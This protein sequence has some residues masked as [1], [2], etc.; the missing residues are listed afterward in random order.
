MTM[1]TRN[2]ALRPTDRLDVSPDDATRL[3]LAEGERVRV[4]SQYGHA[5][6][7]LH[8][9]DSVKPGELFATFSDPHVFLNEL[10]GPHRDALT[11]SPEYKVTAARVERA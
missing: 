8:V 1:R 2:R 9:D 4:S 10:T 6:L 5:I 3:G 11:D 7:P